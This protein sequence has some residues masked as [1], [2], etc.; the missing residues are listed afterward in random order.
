MTEA[1]N[2]FTDVLNVHLYNS[3]FQVWSSEVFAECPPDGANA[4]Q[5]NRGG[6]HTSDPPV[7]CG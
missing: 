5:C 6:K 4:T 3:D 2:T 7:T 1:N